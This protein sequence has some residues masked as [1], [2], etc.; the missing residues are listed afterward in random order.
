MTREAPSGLLR[1]IVAGVR[2]AYLDLE[3]LEDW[4]TEL[5]LAELWQRARAGAPV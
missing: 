5:G 4:V 3:Y 2:G 1:T